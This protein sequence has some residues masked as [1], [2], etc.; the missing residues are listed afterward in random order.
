[1]SGSGLR[2]GRATPP[3]TRRFAA[4]FAA[5]P[6]HFR[7]PDGIELSSIGLG[8][9]GGEPGGADDLLYR[10]AVPLLIEGG[11]NLFDTALSDRMQTSER[12]LGVALDRAFREGLAARDEVFVVTKGG[13]VSIEPELATSPGHARRQLQRDYLETGLVRHLTR[14]VH[15]LDPAFLDDQIERS[16]RNLR[17]ETI[18]LYC[19]EEPELLLREVGGSEF[20]S[21]MRAAFEA[22]E[23]AVGQGRIAAYGL[24]TWEGLLVPHTERNHLSVIDLFDLALEVGGPDHHLRGLQLPYG[25]AM[26]EALRLPSQ[27]GPAGGS[28]A[29]LETLRDTGTALLASAPLAQ[30]GALGRLPHFVG[31]I[32]PGLASDAQRCLQFARST[33][34]ITAA[35]VGM[36]D[37]AH[38]RENLALLRRPPAEP[39]DIDA[40]FQRAALRAAG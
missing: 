3:G 13:F 18:D 10:T 34:G 32:L 23:A 22:L 29:V 40:L 2:P 36:R 39:A 14:G 5:L 35:I 15:C 19:L 11:V 6:G 8:L 31:E 26:A 9:R 16:R 21:R 7:S 4:R 24:A 30:G 12:A 37:E 28:A 20:R 17:L 1:M 27:L 25:I 33:P 38:V